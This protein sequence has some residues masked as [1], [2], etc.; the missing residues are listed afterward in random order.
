MGFE[1]RKKI[2]RKQAVSRMKFDDDGFTL[3][4]DGHQEE[5]RQLLN[6]HYY[7]SLSDL[8]LRMTLIYY[9]YLAS[10]ILYTVKLEKECAFNSL[11]NRVLCCYSVC[12]LL[13]MYYA[14]KMCFWSHKTTFYD[15]L[16]M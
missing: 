14:T 4:Y 13:Y 6:Y 7:Y 12:V 2:K 8:L 10:I 1:K 11:C 16:I 3:I 15:E 5:D 9:Y